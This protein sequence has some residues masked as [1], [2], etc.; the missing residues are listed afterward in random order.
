H[1]AHQPPAVLGP[2]LAGE[3]GHG[4]LVV[5]LAA[6]ADLPEDLAVGEPLLHGGIGQVPRVRGGGTVAL[7]LGAVTHG[8]V[9]LEEGPS[10]AQRLGRVGDGA[11]LGLLG[12]R[13]RP[14]VGPAPGSGQGQERAGEQRLRGRPPHGCGEGDLAGLCGDGMSCG[15]ALGCFGCA[16]ASAAGFGPPTSRADLITTGMRGT[17]AWGGRAVVGTATMRSTTSMPSTTSPKTA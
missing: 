15:D 4:H 6:R 16:G 1:E 10:L 8:A 3:G 12:R 2:D 11:R 17:S 9:S 5:L 14:L 13:R 7:A